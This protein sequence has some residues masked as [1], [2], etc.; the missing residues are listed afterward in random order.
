MIENI[1]IRFFIVDYERLE[2]E[3][4]EVPE[5]EFLAYHGAISYERATIFENGVRQIIL[6]KGLEV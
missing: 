4:I 2:P 6:T 5:V 1:N 3:L